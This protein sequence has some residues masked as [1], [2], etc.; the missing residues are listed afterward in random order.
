MKPRIL[1]ALVITIAV[2]AI[3]LVADQVLAGETFLPLVKSGEAQTGNPTHVLYVFSSGASISGN[4]GGRSGLNKICSNADSSAHACT[5]YEVE[6]AMKT[7][8]VYFKDPFTKS[9]VDTPAKLGTDIVSPQTYLIVGESNWDNLSCEG[10][11]DANSS[12]YATLIKPQGTG[13][14]WANE[15]VTYDNSCDSLNTVACCKWI[16]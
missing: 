3:L 1:L 2:F 8:G 11:T 9:W 14:V 4:V 13:V 16:P 10:W 7:T 12:H 5:L 6:N 15:N